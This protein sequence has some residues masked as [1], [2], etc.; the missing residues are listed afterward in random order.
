MPLHYYWVCD[1]FIV[2][3][4]S[5]GIKL[6]NSAIN[7]LSSS[8]KVNKNNNNLG[9]WVVQKLLNTMGHFMQKNVHAINIV[10]HYYLAV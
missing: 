6:C 3:N 10:Q 2:E 4:R 1:I 9:Y 8:L 5:I 7:T